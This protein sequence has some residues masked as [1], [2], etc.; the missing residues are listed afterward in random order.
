MRGGSLVE[1][2]SSQQG[3]ALR[4]M[5]LPLLLILLPALTL[6]GQGA[7]L[8]ARTEILA[9]TAF[10]HAMQADLAADGAISRAMEDLG[11][12]EGPRVR[13]VSTPLSSGWVD[14]NLWQATSLRWLSSEFF[15]LEG[16]GRRRGWPGVRVKGALGWALDPVTRVGSFRAGLELGGELSVGPGAEATAA[17]P[18]SLPTGWNSGDCAAYAAELD[19]LFSQWTLP[20]AVP[21]PPR[22]SVEGEAPLKIPPLGLFQG[23][24]LLDLALE[25]GSLSTGTLPPSADSGCPDSE[26]ALLVGSDSD[27]EI[28]ERRTCGL[29]VVEGDLRIE[30]SGRIQG[31]AL[32]GGSLI[33]RGSGMFEGLARVRGSV[34]VEESAKILVSTCPAVRALSQ[35][36]S[37]LK[38]L[39]LPGASR[40]PI[41]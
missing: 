11:G 4:G 28:R 23:G 9:S 13:G 6:L 39:L 17:Y 2:P 40:I 1:A 7:L 38:P 34:R 22:D 10:L 31:V 18:L 20:L 30:G 41:F 12:L 15:L 37:L 29:V 26:E 33:L 36:P 14:T 27:L 24:M 32:V 3:M 21:L 25:T 19:S 35:T 8:L 16:R 5:A